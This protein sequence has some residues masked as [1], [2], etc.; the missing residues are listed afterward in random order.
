TAKHTAG[1]VARAANWVM[2]TP[3][4]PV[5]Q[6]PSPHPESWRARPSRRFPQV[7][8]TLAPLLTARSTAGAMVGTGNW[9]MVTPITPV[10]QWPSPHPASW[11]ARPS[12]RFPQVPDT[13]PSRPTARHTAGAV[14]GAANWVMVT[15]IT[16]V[17]QWPSPHPESWRARP[18]RR[19]PQ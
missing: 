4:T 14:A 13:P 12:R 17:F 2:V 10:F 19:F 5:F 7:A 15:P 9:V 6:W 18:S 8:D 11:R 3:I 16:P 1:A